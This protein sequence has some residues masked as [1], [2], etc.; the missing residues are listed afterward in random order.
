MEAWRENTATATTVN[1]SMVMDKMAM[2]RVAR[3]IELNNIV[4]VLSQNYF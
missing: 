1:A 3:V 4:I 2:E